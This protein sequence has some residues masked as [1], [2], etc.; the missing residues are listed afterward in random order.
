MIGGNKVI[1]VVRNAIGLIEDLGG[2]LIG[3][4]SDLDYR[5]TI[6]KLNDFVREYKD[7][8]G[9]VPDNF[10]FDIRNA[11]RRTARE[12]EYEFDKIPPQA[13]EDRVLFMRN[14]STLL[15][16]GSRLDGKDLRVI[17]AG[18]MLAD[19][20]KLEGRLR[21]AQN[22]VEKLAETIVFLQQK[23]E[24][25]EDERKAYTER[26]ELAVNEEVAAEKKK[27]E[28]S[29]ADLEKLLSIKRSYF[30][31]K[32]K[33]V[34][35]LISNIGGKAIS[36]G[37]MKNAI[38][39]RILAEVF[40]I[41]AIVA[42]V[43]AGIYLWEHMDRLMPVSMDGFQLISR[44][45]IAL[46][47]SFVVAYFVRQSSVHRVQQHRYQQRAYDLS[48]IDTYISTLPISE[49]REI[50]LKIAEKLLVPPEAYAS[51]DASGFGVNELVAKLIDKLEIPK[52]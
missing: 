43:G 42:M 8:N 34:N 1:D 19:V 37:F 44:F 47:F 36:G 10:I 30:S 5:N 13:A 7:K 3:S 49:Q 16:E 20:G 24:K 12:F 2:F 18:G 27:I 14:L 29:S 52:K 25:Y 4:G 41:L 38:L 51:M 17:D 48:A 31:D 39:E 15:G 40:R 35:K 11:I 50:K 46:F 23:V 33:E 32:E 28:S 9:D 6:S 45:G 22:R 21:D 26:F